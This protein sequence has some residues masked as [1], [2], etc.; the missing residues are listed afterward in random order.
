MKSQLGEP[1]NRRAHAR[2][3]L[4]ART[5]AVPRRGEAAPRPRQRGPG[6]PVLLSAPDRTGGFFLLPLR[7]VGRGDAPARRRRRDRRGACGRGVAP[8][9]GVGHARSG[10]CPCRAGVGRRTGRPGAGPAAGP[11]G[12]VPVASTSRAEDD[13]RRS[14]PSNGRLPA[15]RCADRPVPA[16]DRRRRRAAGRGGLVVPLPAER[17]RAAGFRECGDPGG[18][19]A[20]GGGSLAPP[21]SGGRRRRGSTPGTVRGR[22]A[23]LPAPRRPPAA[24]TRRG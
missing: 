2:G 14:R 18:G 10:A 24:A 3:A 7:R 9:P 11:R 8:H 1:V 16:A 13:G 22:C 4:Y 5:S 17:G 20:G 23:P 21:P 6:R 15:L 19:N 12:M